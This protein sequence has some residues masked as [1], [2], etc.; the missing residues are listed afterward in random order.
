MSLPD[1]SDEGSGGEH[2]P[3]TSLSG[4]KEPQPQIPFD[5]GA[6]VEAI[7]AAVWVTK[8]DGI[9]QFFNRFYLD[10]VGLSLEEALKEGIRAAVHPDD[11]RAF[12]Q[13]FDEVG[14]R[15]LA[16]QCELRMRGADGIYRWFI[17][18]L[19]PSFD[20]NSRLLGC[21]GTCINIEERKKVEAELRRNEA[22]LAQGQRLTATGSTWWNV[23]TG[24][25]IWSEETYRQMGY[26]PD[27]AP[28]V[29]LAMNRLHPEDAERVAAT[30]LG[31]SAKGLDI[32]MEHRLMMPDGRVTHCRIVL[33]NQQDSEN[34]V[35][36]GAMAN[37]TDWKESEA[38]ERRNA[39]L[40]AAGERIGRTGTFSWI[41]D[42]KDLTASPEFRRILEFDENENITVEKCLSRIVPEDV[43][44][45]IGK[46]PGT[47]AEMANAEHDVR[48]RA[49]DGSIRHI[50]FIGQVET[51]EDGREECLGAVRDVTQ[52]RQAEEMLDQLRTELS[53]LTGAMSIAEMAASVAHE[54][55]QPLAGM[56]ANASTVLRMLSTE[57]PDVPAALE[58][59]RRGLRDAN[60][61]AEVVQR[62]RALFRKEL[63]VMSLVD[64]NGAV[65]EVLLLLR[66]SI[67]RNRIALRSE[68]ALEL[69]LVRGDR[70]QLQQVVMN[71]L[72]NAIE[73]LEHV[74][75]RPKSVQVVTGLTGDG[76]AEFVVQD[77]GPGLR[78]EDMAR[79]FEPY[80]TSKP[81]GMGVGLFLSKSI[82]ESH[83]GR[84]FMR[85]QTGFGAVFGF[86]LPVAR[87]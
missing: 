40:L 64:L 11:D 63:P 66:S 53:R 47:L 81:H 59:A 26:P 83:G 43:A 23:K 7:P 24:E 10:Y 6:M 17:C 71:M 45:L 65:R 41:T 52:Q 21:C 34:P 55:N 61:G 3:N 77:N 60:R 57:T 13:L 67:R 2:D 48:I 32:D 28:T 5:P 42:G 62:L 56:V 20:A 8:P 44:T 58:A 50:K 31:N 51:R 12:V 70:V 79:M 9:V 37:I 49:T 87:S 74:S 38:R 68:L 75:D 82:V 39:L 78:P 80:Y 19:N 46:T 84:I 36:V 27:V 14:K 69:P 25:I 16:L 15:K 72:K 29:D 4:L 1:N 54:V 76:E 18:S 33:H 73:T 85:P 30:I 22:F 35:Y 86:T